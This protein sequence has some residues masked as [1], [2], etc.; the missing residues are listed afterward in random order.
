MP[1][2]KALTDL[3]L[4]EL[5]EDASLASTDKFLSVDPNT[6][7]PKTA[8]LSALATLFGVSGFTGLTSSVTELNKSDVSAQSET[9]DS[10]VAASVLVKNT[11]IDNT[12]TGAGAITLDVPDASMLGLIKTIEMTVDN[13]NVT[14]A[15]TNV[16]GGSD[17]TTATFA[18][19][20]D[21]LVL[22]GGTS[23][24]HVIGESGV[25]LS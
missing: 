2:N 13:G 10:G 14:L 25:V 11:K 8:L 20:N 19:V 15:L 18:D 12:T 9:I 3:G 17:T 7:E 4:N 5:S 24:W 1:D 22:V 6:N 21:C 16:Q 23:K